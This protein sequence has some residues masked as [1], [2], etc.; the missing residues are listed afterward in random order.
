MPNDLHKLIGLSEAIQNIRAL[1]KQVAPTDISILITGE[2]GT[3]K[4]VVAELIHHNSPRSEK[5]L[6]TVNCGAIPEGIFESE[7]FGHE[8]GSFTGAD[9]QRKGYF[10]LADGG[11]IFLDEI[12][13]MPLQAQVKI[14]R[15]LETGEFMRVGGNTNINVDVRVITATNRDIAGAVVRGEFRSDLYYRLKAVNIHLPSLNERRED[16]PLLVEHF[17]AD[18]CQHNH[19]PVPEIT[20]EGLEL[21]VEHR[22][23]GNVREL[24][25]FV[26]SLITLERG[27]IFNRENISRLLNAQQT[28]ASSQ[29]PVFMPR[30]QEQVEREMLYR[31]LMDLRREIWELRLMLQELLEHQARVEVYP[32]RRTSGEVRSLSL[33][34]ME[35]EQI[36][37]AL[38]KHHGN[39]RLAA[40]ALGVGE[41]TLYRKLKE[42]GLS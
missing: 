28:S 37:R 26:E 3:G 9:K 11:T 39:R 35:K 33:E 12:G 8:R 25:N 32:R 36:R 41:R 13:E 40:K 5:P 18:F 14:L 21:L 24:K 1:I 30:Y 27:R 10:E 29:L 38:E 31:T 34:E 17:I 7:V 42:Y 19:I 16:I 22:W 15:I 2:S 6:I 20:E 23:E 4:E